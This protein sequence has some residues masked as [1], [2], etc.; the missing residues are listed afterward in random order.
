MKTVWLTGLLVFAALLPGCVK[1]ETKVTLT[2][3]SGRYGYAFEGPVGLQGTITKDNL[4]DAAWKVEG[5][6]IFPTG[7]YE[8]LE[9]E[10]TVAESYPEQVFIKFKVIVPGPND[11]VA[12]VYSEQ[13]FSYLVTASNEAAFSVSVTTLRSAV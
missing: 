12:M 11:I 6:F 7:G 10:I 5:K 3:L 8:L 9:P 1:E 4:T 13:P 2:P